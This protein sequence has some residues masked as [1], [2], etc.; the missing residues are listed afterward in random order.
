MIDTIEQLAHDWTQ[1]EQFLDDP[2]A[3][4]SA[5]VGLSDDERTALAARDVRALSALGFGTMDGLE[6]FMSG[7]HTAAGCTA[8]CSK[9]LTGT[10][11]TQVDPD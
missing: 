4:A 5:V 6:V 11:I 9:D 3:F 7:A 10:I 1:V 2:T 8:G